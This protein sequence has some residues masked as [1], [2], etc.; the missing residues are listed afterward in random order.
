MLLDT[1]SRPNFL[2]L[3]QAFP[4]QVMIQ[5]ANLEMDQAMKDIS[6]AAGSKDAPGTQFRNYFIDITKV[7]S[8]GKMEEAE[9]FGQKAIDICVAQNWPHLQNSVLVA[10]GSGWKNL[11]DMDKALMHFQQGEGIALSEKKAGNDIAAVLYPNVLF[12]KGAAY[13]NKGDFE[14][15]AT[16]YEKIPE[17]VGENYQ[18]QLEGW[19]MAGFSYDKLGAFQEAHEAYEKALLVSDQMDPETLGDTSLFFVG[20]ALIRLN[21]LIVRGRRLREF[22][23]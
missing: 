5:E 9:Q 19:R 10:L 12:A 18:H 15:A 13:I 7:A 3:Q 16:T 14:Q 4:D 1:I 2:D 17:N 20:V 21:I 8:K 23:D 6:N 22:F 11:K